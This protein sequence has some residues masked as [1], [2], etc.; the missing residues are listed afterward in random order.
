MTLPQTLASP[1]VH[2]AL[3]LA[4]RALSKTCHCCN[5]CP[6]RASLNALIPIFWLELQQEPLISF[7]TKD[8]YGLFSLFF[9]GYCIAEF[10][11][12]ERSA[13][14]TLFTGHQRRWLLMPC[15][16]TWCALMAWPHGPQHES[17]GT[18]TY[19]TG[20]F[21]STKSIKIMAHSSIPLTY[22]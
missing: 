12:F 17:R 22:N 8:F 2:K 21:T 11:C 4:A 3:C 16:V 18:R 1:T 19:P 15:S 6:Q 13:N 14:S 10:E 7:A 9:H 20:D 5:G